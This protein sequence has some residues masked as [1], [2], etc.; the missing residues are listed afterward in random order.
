MRPS[1]QGCQCLWP[2]SVLRT[3]SEE[4]CLRV[5]STPRR[6]QKSQ[7]PPTWPARAWRSH[8]PPLM[9]S[10]RP[11]PWLLRPCTLLQAGS[12]CAAN[13]FIG[14]DYACKSTQSQRHIAASSHMGLQ[15]REIGSHKVV[16]AFRARSH[17]LS[18]LTTPVDSAQNSRHMAFAM[19]IWCARA[20][21]R[22][23]S[24]AS[25]AVEVRKLS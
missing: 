4:P 5:E 10:T 6:A 3:R 13:C 8:G 1:P 17:M 19:G 23:T 12:R 21:G 24:C 20:V 7:C 9:Q 16:N 2:R 25:I 22:H 14:H 15:R 11:Q 18:S